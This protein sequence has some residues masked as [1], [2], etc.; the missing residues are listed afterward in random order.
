[1]REKWRQLGRVCDTGRAFQSSTMRVCLFG[2]L[3]LGLHSQWWHLSHTSIELWVFLCNLTFLENFSGLPSSSFCEQGHI[4]SAQCPELAVNLTSL[5]LAQLYHLVAGS[6]PVVSCQKQIYSRPS[7]LDCFL[8]ADR[9]SLSR[10][11]KIPKKLMFWLPVRPALIP[12]VFMT[13]KWC[14]TTVPAQSAS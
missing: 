6:R 4:F 10:S 12:D 8:N 7:W 13:F 2:D 5:T 9:I 3:S 11:Q 14:N 1:M